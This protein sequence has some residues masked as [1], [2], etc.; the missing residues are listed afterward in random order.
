MHVVENTV[1]DVILDVLHLV[2]SD[3]GFM[4]V[5]LLF[6]AAGILG[7]HLLQTIMQLVHILHSLWVRRTVEIDIEM[8][9][10]LFEPDFGLFTSDAFLV[11]KTMPPQ[12]IAFLPSLANAMQ[13]TPP[14]HHVMLKQ[15]DRKSNVASCDIILQLSS[16]VHGVPESLGPFHYQANK[17]ANDPSQGE[18]DLVGRQ[19]GPFLF[20]HQFPSNIAKLQQVPSVVACG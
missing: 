18:H 16:N 17:V 12:D 10:E 5:D 2:A 7:C 20:R 3:E 13:V 8:H 19:V 1:E 4:V 14:F 11:E 9:V 15:Q 6:D